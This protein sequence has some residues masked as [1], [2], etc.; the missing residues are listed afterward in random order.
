MILTRLVVF[1][2][3]VLFQIHFTL[4]YCQTFHQ[5]FYEKSPKLF[6]FDSMKVK[7]EMLL[8]VLSL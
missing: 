7:N 2:I 6:M 3:S 4:D 1:D 5:N 8:E